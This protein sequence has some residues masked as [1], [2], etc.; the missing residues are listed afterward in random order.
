MQNCGKD[1]AD[2]LIKLL[3][4]AAIAYFVYKKL[5][6]LALQGGQSS[7]K[8]SGREN[9]PSE[10]VMIQDPFCKTWFPGRDAVHLR[11]DGEDFYFCST[12]CRDSFL[13]A[14]SERQNR[15]VHNMKSE[16]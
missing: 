12:Q 5:K 8:V 1:S 4:I 10:D 14:R 13:S 11:I 7:H 3:I 2:R 16:K 6:S 15:T 9:P